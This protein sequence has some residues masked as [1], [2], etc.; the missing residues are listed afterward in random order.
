MSSAMDITYTIFPNLSGAVARQVK[1]TW[2]SLEEQA[3]DPASHATKQAMPLLKLATFGDSRSANGSLR[4][5][6][7][8]QQVFGLEVEHDAGEMSPGVAAKLL[9]DSGITAVVYT[10]PS[11]TPER[12]RWRALLPLSSPCAVGDR[13]KHVGMVNAILNGALAPESFTAAQS[14]YFGKVENKPYEAIPVRGGR[15]IDE[16]KFPYG[17]LY[18]AGALASDG[19]TDGDMHDALRFINV[20]DETIEEVRAAVAALSPHRCEP[21][22]YFEWRE[23]ICALKSLEH[24]GHGQAAW[25]MAVEFST[26]GGAAFD[27]KALERKWREP[28]RK[29]TYKTILARA[30]EDGWRNPKCAGSAPER[31]DGGRTDL[32]DTGNCNVLYE[33]TA[34]NLRYIHETAKWMEWN[35]K[36]WTIDE[37]G[38]RARV[39]TQHVAEKYRKLATEKEAEAD[40]AAGQDRRRL[41]KIAERYR[42]WHL[43]CRNRRGI[44]NMLALAARDDRFIISVTQLDQDPWAL[45]VA[46]GVVDLRSGTLRANGREDF[47]TKRCGIEFD[48]DAKAPIFEK[49]IDEITA[50]PVIGGFNYRAELAAYLQRAVGYWATGNTNEH[51]MFVLVGP[52]AAGKSLFTECIEAVMSAYCTI[53]PPEALMATSRPVDAERP[54]PY[55]RALAGARIAMASEA[56][57]GDKLNAAWVKRQTGD[58]KITARGMKENAYTFSVTHKLILI[59]NHEPRLDHFDEATRSRIHMVPFDCRWNRPGVPRDPNLPDGDKSLK[60]K[61]MAEA[62]GILSWIVAGAVAYAHEGL[63]PPPQVVAKTAAYFDQQ[64]TFSQWL[65]STVPCEPR[66]GT[67]ATALFNEFRSYCNDSGSPNASPSTIH[68][69]ARELKTRGV[70]TERVNAGTVYGLTSAAALF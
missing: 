20:S 30:Q 38:A 60:I 47:I 26:R 57:D 18:P 41:Q 64:D 23:I 4:H 63:E 51:K 35:G 8:M 16:L 48:P 45:G 6:N 14:F 67:Q 44:E 42:Q 68:A 55:A 28:T 56:K 32:T 33:V 7:N 37:A 52:P 34:G 31:P 22:S 24:A 5:T 66:S 15:C 40:L 59:T 2:Q 12:P 27:I 53:I 39:A 69:F 11:H 19:G 54:T 10:T 46:N 58:A 21:G 17:P 36:V 61:L 70:K 1:G 3:M 9:A 49:F 62:Q 13:H 43:Q 25:D 29:M 65:R 50:T